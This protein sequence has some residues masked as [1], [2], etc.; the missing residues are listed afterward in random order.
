[1][2]GEPF[3]LQDTLD[4]RIFIGGHGDRLTHA[5]VTE[6][7]VETL[8]DVI[9]IFIQPVLRVGGIGQIEHQHGDARRGR[10]EDLQIWII[11]QFLVARLR[12]RNDGEITRQ[13]AIHFGVVI[14]YRL[15]DPGRRIDVTHEGIGE[16]LVGDHRDLL[17]GSE[18]AEHEGASGDRRRLIVFVIRHQSEV[19]TDRLLPGMSGDD[20]GEAL[21]DVA[22]QSSTVRRIHLAIFI[23]IHPQRDDDGFVIRRF[24]GLN[25]AIFFQ[26]H[27][28][29]RRWRLATADGIGGI[30]VICRGDGRAIAPEDVITQMDGQHGAGFIIFPTGGHASSPT[31]CRG[32]RLRI[33]GDE[34][35]I[36]PI[37]D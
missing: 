6:Q 23:R 17:A 30:D 18:F 3:A 31:R 22:D 13:E 26:E 15:Q 10:F 8:I 14:G 35:D 12:R 29:S 37:D 11:A 2:G 24:D 7:R 1:M 27:G 16:A 36:L 5:Q 20:A 33:D 19:L 21:D 4:D 9:A 34:I 25:G 28:Y 32:F